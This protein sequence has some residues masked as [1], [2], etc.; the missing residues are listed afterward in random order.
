MPIT[1]IN[2][3]DVEFATA[4]GANYNSRNGR[5]DFDAPLS[6]N[7]GLT[8]TSMAT[9]DSPY[10]FDL[11]ETYD[12]TWVDNGVVKTMTGAE[13][14][15]TDDF[16]ATQGLVVF[17]GVDQFGN[18][19]HVLWTPGLDVHQ[20]YLDNFNG[21]NPPVFYNGD[22]SAET[23]GYI[24]FAA[25]AR[26][27]TARGAR[28]VG[29]LGP[30]DLVWSLDRGLVPVTWVGRRRA[31]GRG[32]GAPVLFAPGTLGNHA[33]LRLSP[34]HRVMLSGPAVEDHAGAP[35]V[36]VPAKA[37][38]GCAGVRRTDCDS[39]VYVNF[40]C[41]AHEVVLAEGAACETLWLGDEATR[42]I[43]AGVDPGGAFVGLGALA[44][45]PR[46]APARP[47]FTVGQTS[48]LVAAIGIG[49]LVDERHEMDVPDF[50]SA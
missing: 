2:A 3:V 30:G 22:R 21:R 26:V 7:S 9:D 46:V 44:S 34:Q 45:G 16:S 4:T 19:A 12:L 28:P 10:R 5:S 11:G 32:E 27:L 18:P 47:M 25:E 29:D 14:V 8:I 43:D 23:Y 41:D 40:L 49:A 39:I 20:W 36:L 37:L 13:V 48:R 6:Q 24:C 31:A 1:T 17:Q 42:V 50:L 15:R 38:V 33:P 35:E